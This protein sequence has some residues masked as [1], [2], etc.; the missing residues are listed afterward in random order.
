MKC[1]GQ[2][3]KIILR[4]VLL[5]GG[6]CEGIRMFRNKITISVRVSDSCI[7]MCGLFK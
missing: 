2:R 7:F 4:N 1:E 3:D 6:L 5:T